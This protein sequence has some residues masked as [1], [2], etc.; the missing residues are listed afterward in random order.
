M[1]TQSSYGSQNSRGAFWAACAAALFVLANFYPEWWLLSF[2]SA[3]SVTCWL[4]PP[5]RRFLRESR[6]L[7]YLGGVHW[8]F[9]W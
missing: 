1:L 2:F 3:L 9:P 5:A 6:A 4:Y 7:R 8:A